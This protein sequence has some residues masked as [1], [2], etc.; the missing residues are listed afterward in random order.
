MSDDAGY[1]LDCPLEGDEVVV[2]TAPLPDNLERYTRRHPR[3]PVDWAASLD[4]GAMVT[5]VRVRDVSESGAGVETA[6]Q[7]RVGDRGVL[8]LDQLPGQPAVQVEV[9][10][11]MPSAR[12]VGLGFDAG[13][14]VPGRLVAA[15][16]KRV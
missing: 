10:N 3:C 16:R 1:E 7:L 13:G 5:S 8:R 2:A 14:D 11:V 12:R 15:A 9:K 4:L 6:M